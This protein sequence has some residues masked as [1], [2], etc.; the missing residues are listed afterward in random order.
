MIGVNL[1][2]GCGACRAAAII[3][4]ERYLLSLRRARS[5]PAGG[6]S[7]RAGQAVS[8]SLDGRY[9]PFCRK[10][11]PRRASSARKAVEARRL[12]IATA[13]IPAAAP[14]PLEPS[15]SLIS[16]MWSTGLGNI[17]P[18]AARTPRSSPQIKP[19]VNR[20]L[21]GG[22]STPTHQGATGES[23][24]MA[25]NHKTSGP[26]LLAWKWGRPSVAPVFW[27]EPPQRGKQCKTRDFVAT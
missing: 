21:R 25:R 20:Q 15:S 9:F 13:A 14:M 4:G 23:T 22:I 8:C 3:C 12:R 18:I 7:S 10:S 16:W 17:S 1:S 27:Q 19:D 11:Y 24:P 6:K 26:V 2:S 5:L